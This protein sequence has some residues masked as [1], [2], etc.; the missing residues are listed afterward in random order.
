M[1]TVALA[2]ALLLAGESVRA[3]ESGRASSRP[4]PFVLQDC[5]HLPAGSGALCGDFEVY[6]NRAAGAGR[7]IALH[8]IVL[9][10]T[11][12]DPRPDPIFLLAGGPGQAATSF[13]RSYLRGGLRAQRDIVMVDQRGTG[14]GNLLRCRLA[15]S[16]ENL[17]GYLDPI[18]EV[19]LFS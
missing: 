11:G 12:R 17:Q 8:V 13:A 5:T 2:V 10:A 6:E 19:E 9:P 7:V 15:G 4:A 1:R 18:F 16:D 14:R 3:Q